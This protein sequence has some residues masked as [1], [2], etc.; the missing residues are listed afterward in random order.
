[1]TIKRINKIKTNS[2]NR[3]KQLSPK[4]AS[5]L[6]TTLA[7]RSSKLAQKRSCRLLVVQT[8]TCTTPSILKR[9]AKVSR[10][11]QGKQT[12]PQLWQ[13]RQEVISR[14]LRCLREKRP[15][16]HRRRISRNPKMAKKVHRRRKSH[17]AS[18]ERSGGR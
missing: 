14:C 12:P 10:Q 18:S 8:T 11:L 2:I 4:P 17:F 15:L 6:N 13:R 5:S 3:L 16:V 9:H 7:R 1:M